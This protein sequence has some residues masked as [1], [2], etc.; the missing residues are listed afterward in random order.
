MSGRRIIIVGA[1]LAGLAAAEALSRRARG[2]E[3]IVLEAK[4]ITGGRAGSY[5]DPHS[6]QEV[7]Y[8]QHAAMGCCTNLLDLLKRCQLAG[9]F[10]RVRE[11]TFLHPTSP[12]SRFAPQ[13]LLPP[14]L[15]LYRTVDALRYLSRGQKRQVKA[16]LWKLLRTPASTLATQTAA[17]WLAA[18]GQSQATIADFWDVIL[19]SALG[20]QTER[21]SMAAARKVLI[22]GFAAARGAS[23]VLVPTRPLAELFGRQL[24]QTL[25]ERGVQLRTGTSV[26]A[27]RADGHVVTREQTF[28]ADAVIAAVPWHQIGRLL[29]EWG[30]ASPR[31]LDNLDAI[32]AIPGSS[33]TGLHLWF[34]SAITP[35]PHA[36]MVGTTSQWLFRDP[37]ETHGPPLPAAEPGGIDRTGGRY[38]QVVISGSHELV[39]SGKDALVD[40]VVAE[41]RHAF[42]RARQARLLRHRV[43]TDPQSVFSIRPDV[44]RIRP[45]A[46]TPVPWFFL[47]GDWTQ[48]GWPAT[49]EGAVVS[50]RQAATAVLDRFPAL[51]D[52]P[53]PSPAPL[54]EPGLTAGWL[55]RWL[56]R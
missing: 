17:Q 18:A 36:V 5:H 2:A 10:K 1:G 33:I 41:L 6:G 34:D 26:R 15:H 29:A 42:P 30:A 25:A 56:I 49:M 22:D 53:A 51:A 46:N 8:C 44:E 45:A 11:L 13:R 43:V 19:V 21:V 24:P 38:H 20:E 28:P 23:D 16:G 52:S 12:P 50:G 14:P 4:R 32:D 37:L 31:P 35:Q 39:A 40:H 47:A 55:A 7:D 48:T 9:H 54:V 3:I 27:I